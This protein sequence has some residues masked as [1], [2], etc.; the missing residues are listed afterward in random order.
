MQVHGDGVLRSVHPD[1]LDAADDHV[2]EAVIDLVRLTI[3]VRHRCGPHC[4]TPISPNFWIAIQFG[5]GGRL[6]LMP[7]GRDRL[8]ATC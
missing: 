7:Q 3:I 8:D 4:I 6:S 5:I 1:Q 2:R